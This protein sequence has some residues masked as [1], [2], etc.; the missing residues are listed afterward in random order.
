MLIYIYSTLTVSTCS[1]DNDK[2]NPFLLH[3]LFSLNSQSS[4]CASDLADCA[5]PLT[6]DFILTVRGLETVSVC[7]SVCSGVCVH[8]CVYVFNVVYE[9]KKNFQ[10]KGSRVLLIACGLPL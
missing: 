8:V 6:P 4:Y 2:N 7:V 9:K 5:Q 3:F 10:R 1:L